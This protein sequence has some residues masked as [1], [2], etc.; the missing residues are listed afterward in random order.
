M[1]AGTIGTVTTSRPPVGPDSDDVA[2]LEPDSDDVA[3]LRHLL[4][5]MGNFPSNDQRARYLLTCDWMRDRGAVAAARAGEIAADIEHRWA[6]VEELDESEWVSELDA[7]D[8][9]DDVD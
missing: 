2:A 1:P 9:D 3:A 6:D 7:P 5:M 8:P 4:D